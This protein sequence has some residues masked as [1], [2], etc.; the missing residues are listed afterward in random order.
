MSKNKKINSSIT[1]YVLT[2]TLDVSSIGKYTHLLAL[3]TYYSITRLYCL[4]P[5]VLGLILINLTQRYVRKSSILQWL[6]V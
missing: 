1:Y 4:Q 5:I 2:M 6:Q 3:V